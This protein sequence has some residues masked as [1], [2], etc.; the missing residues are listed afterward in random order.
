MMLRWV[1]WVLVFG[2]MMLIELFV[3]E[4]ACVSKLRLF[5]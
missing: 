2:D 1:V 3:W 5:G 4:L